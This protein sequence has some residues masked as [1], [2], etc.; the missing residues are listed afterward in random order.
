[1]VTEPWGSLAF[2]WGAESRHLEDE[3]WLAGT[4]GGLCTYG[5]E[6]LTESR[7]AS[8]CSEGVLVEARE[9]YINLEMY[10]MLKILQKKPRK[11][12][13]EKD[14]DVGNYRINHGH[15]FRLLNHHIHLMDVVF[16]M[17]A[18]PACL[19]AE[20]PPSALGFAHL[21][22][23][24]AQAWRVQVSGWILWK[25]FSCVHESKSTQKRFHSVIF[26]QNRIWRGKCFNT[27]I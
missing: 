6:L 21:L 19:W 2:G 8:C 5:A 12:C 4:D 10:G 18:G 23:R 24:A 14:Q 1:M 13:E 16:I 22:H 27:C 11:G 20:I 7:L 25:R 9:C 3:Y 26:I 17:F 15:Q